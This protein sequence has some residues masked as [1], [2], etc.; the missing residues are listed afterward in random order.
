MTGSL[1]LLHCQIISGVKAAVRRVSG[2]LVPALGVGDL[3]RRDENEE[4]EN[5]Q[6]LSL[7]SY[8]VNSIE[9]TVDRRLLK[10]DG[11]FFFDIAIGPRM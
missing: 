1:H 10:S 5:C 3:E 9:H 7:D 11:G 6:A 4:T 8:K 2:S